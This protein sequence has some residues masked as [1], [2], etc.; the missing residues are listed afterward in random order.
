MRALFTPV[1]PHEQVQWVVIVP[2][3]CVGMHPV[4]LRVSIAHGSRSASSAERGASLAAFPRRAW[5]RSQSTHQGRCTTLSRP[6]LPPPQ[7]NRSPPS[8][9][10]PDTPL[11][12]GSLRLSSTS[13][14]FGSTRRNSLSS[15]SQVP[16][17]S[18]PSTQV[19]PVTK[20]LD[21]RV[22]RIVPVSG[23]IWWIFRSRYWPT[24]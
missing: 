7:K 6:L 23:S 16:C 8:D 22:R 1:A 9:S 12:S 20:R 24:H 21:C 2:T 10:R 14:V 17:H 5:E 4:T 19:T 13:P 3:L 15:S 18:A 11:P